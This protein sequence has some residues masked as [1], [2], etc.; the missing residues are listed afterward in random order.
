MKTPFYTGVGDAGMTNTGKLHLPK[1]DAVFELLG[2]LDECNCWLGYAAGEASKLHN[3]KQIHT[4]LIGLQ[5]TVFIA[6]AEVAAL[7]FSYG[8]YTDSPRTFPYLRKKHI[9]LLQR[10][11]R[12]IDGEYPSLQHFILPGGSELSSRCDIARTIAR[13]AE[14]AAIAVQGTYSFSPTF[15]QY[16]NR[17][18]SVLFALARY[19]NFRAGVG[20]NSPTY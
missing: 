14:R 2:S 9:T 6:Q 5:Q 12:H 1:S 8:T 13:R 17:L 11:I 16:L 7:A 18:S 3:E 10:I 20:E 19:A 15:L 4:W